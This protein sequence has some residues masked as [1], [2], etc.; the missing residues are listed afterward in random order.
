MHR[1]VAFLRGI[2]VG[3]K[4]IIK[5]EVLAR[6]FERAGFL[7]VKTYIQSGN[8]LFS[9]E[10]SDIHTLEKQLEAMMLTEFNCQTRILVR[11]K[12]QMSTVV[13]GFPEVFSN[14]KWKHNV[15]FL[16]PEIDR[17]TI[18]EELRHKQDIELL[19]YLP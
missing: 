1:Y 12:E 11:S 9:S 15:I 2:N 16:T 14:A 19:V 4:N 10:E 5:M 13:A 6:A 8:V 3:G 7:Q 18:I 17:A